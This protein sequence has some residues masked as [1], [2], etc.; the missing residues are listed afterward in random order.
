MLSRFD[1]ERQLLVGVLCGLALLSH[2][3][4]QIGPVNTP[5]IFQQ[6]QIVRVCMPNFNFNKIEGWVTPTTDARDLLFLTMFY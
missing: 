4:K 6:T 1:S 2:C 3:S 5:Q